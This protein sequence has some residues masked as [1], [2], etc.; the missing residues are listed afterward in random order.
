LLHEPL[1]Q[2]A[3]CIVDPVD[4]GGWPVSLLI[5][6]GVVRCAAPARLSVPSAEASR[7]EAWKNRP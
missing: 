7:D 1:S 2:Y 5:S 4:F 6:C 3:K